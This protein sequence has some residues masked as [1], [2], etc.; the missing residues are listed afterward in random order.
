MRDIRHRGFFQVILDCFDEH[1]HTPIIRLVSVP[2][3]PPDWRFG[4]R[5]DGLG[6]NT[7]GGEFMRVVGSSY[8]LDPE[9]VVMLPGIL[10]GY[11]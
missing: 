10:E 3:L 4:V 7:M 6:R 11:C 8:E 1:P 5:R 9:G 2:L